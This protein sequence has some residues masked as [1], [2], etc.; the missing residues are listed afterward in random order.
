[1]R[2]L[3]PTVAFVGLTRHSHSSS[4][5]SCG[6][7]LIRFLSQDKRDRIVFML[8]QFTDETPTH[9]HTLI[10]SGRALTRLT[11]VYLLSDS[12]SPTVRF[13]GSSPGS[14]CLSLLRTRE[15][16]AFYALFFDEVDKHQFECIVIVFSSSDIIIRLMIHTIEENRSL[17]TETGRVFFLFI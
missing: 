11:G 3:H 17:T 13:N 1:M 2:R 10:K 16:F 5:S 7:R 14:T 4:P 12:L 15:Y 6:S 8:E 9:A